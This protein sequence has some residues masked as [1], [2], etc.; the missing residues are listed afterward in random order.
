MVPSSA[1]LHKQGSKSV[2]GQVC[3]GDLVAK[4]APVKK[5][6][7]NA[8]G[9]QLRSVVEHREKLGFS[10]GH[11]GLPLWILTF[12]FDLSSQ[13]NK[14]HYEVEHLYRPTHGAPC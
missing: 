8:K 11:G 2:S 6:K 12:C 9:K 7:R 4:P 10:R 5:Q 13:Q 14:L 3:K 1:E